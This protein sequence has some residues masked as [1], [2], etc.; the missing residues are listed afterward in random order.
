M[1]GVL[2]VEQV[3]DFQVKIKEWLDLDP[4]N[5][6]ILTGSIAFTIVNKDMGD[7]SF[8]KAYLEYDDELREF[9][10][11]VRVYGCKAFL[12]KPHNYDFLAARRVDTLNTVYE[13]S[14]YKGLA[15]FVNYYSNANFRWIIIPVSHFDSMLQLQ[16]KIQT[17]I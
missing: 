10:E 3:A 1:D 8:G 17:Y 2:T 15:H 7:A 16:K 13:D 9:L 5:I 12:L 4:K 11:M 14:V 6:A